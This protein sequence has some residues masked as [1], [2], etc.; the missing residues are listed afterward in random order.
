MTHGSPLAY[1]LAQTPDP[2]LMC[3][4]CVDKQVNVIMAIR[5]SHIQFQGR[6]TRTLEFNHQLLNV[7]A[8]Y[9]QD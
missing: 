4:L 5:R 9:L 7:S 2:L 6:S 1:S 8:T 3:I